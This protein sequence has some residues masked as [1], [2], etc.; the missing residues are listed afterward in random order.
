M[1]I[2]AHVG[3][4]DLL[5]QIRN[6]DVPLMV[7]VSGMSFA[8]TYNPSENYTSYFIK[9][10]KRL[11]LPVWVFLSLY[12][13]FMFIF[14]PSS[15]D[16]QIRKVIE[17]YLLLNGIGYV[18]IIRVFVLVAIL[19][20]LLFKINSYI[21]S[22]RTFYLIITCAIF[23]YET[24]RILTFDMI[25]TGIGHIVSLFIYYM[26]AYSAVFMLGM[27]LFS[28]D[29]TIL[30]SFS[31]M[32]LIIFSALA[33]F[34]WSQHGAF[35]PTQ[36]FKYPPSL[37]YLSYALFV[38]SSLWFYLNLSNISL[39]RA[40]LINFISKYSMWIYLWHIVFIKSIHCSAFIKFIL[41]Y[42]FA[43]VVA[44]LQL[45]FI[46]YL[47]SKLKPNGKAAKNLKLIFI[48]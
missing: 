18:W 22:N 1:I 36:E 29:K 23:A 40:N 47:I 31:T 4:T 19:A 39:I 3:A 6:F 17:S 9:R 7:L 5:F 11:V 34:Y 41:V 30:I 15:T 45:L 16:L 38:S 21:S 32:N 14:F 8:L 35:I 2:I 37:Y 33:M 48:G 43:I 46:N 27:R 10:I 20:P 25:Q 26:I 28:T 12:F 42:T 24:L 44:W 13:V